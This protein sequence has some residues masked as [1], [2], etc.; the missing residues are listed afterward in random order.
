[1]RAVILPLLA[2]A[3]LAAP[4]F[5]QELLPKE[6][7]MPMQ[8]KPPFS[9]FQ[10]PPAERFAA[11]DTDHD[12]KVTKAEFKAVLNPTAQQSIERIWVNRDTNN[13]GWLTEQEMNAN[14]PSR[15]GGRGQAA[16]AAAAGAGAAAAPQTP[17]E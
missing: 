10:L 2:S 6:G 17:T 14:G 5:A 12:G 7:P 1:M 15:L 4:A 9:V 16:A 8:G 11:T 3:C 13:D